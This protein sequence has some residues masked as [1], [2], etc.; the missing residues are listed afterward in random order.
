LFTNFGQSAAAAA[1]NQPKRK[2]GRAALEVFAGARWRTQPATGTK[3]TA[4]SAVVVV[5]VV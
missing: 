4:T 1:A 3:A 5:V 2:I